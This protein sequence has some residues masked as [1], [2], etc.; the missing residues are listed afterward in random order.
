VLGDRNNIGARHFGNRDTAVRLVGGIEIYV[1]GANSSSDSEL[2]I[3]GLGQTL[4]CQ[5]AGVESAVS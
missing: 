4:G 3:L 2:E 5:V 1:I